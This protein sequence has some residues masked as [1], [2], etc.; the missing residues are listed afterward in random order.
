MQ[1]DAEGN[2]RPDRQQYSKGYPRAI[3]LK[4]F[5]F[6]GSASRTLEKQISRRVILVNATN[7]WGIFQCAGESKGVHAIFA[8]ADLIVS[9]Q[10]ALF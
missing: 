10:F 6:W 9:D 7:L 5:G 8:V 4:A 3:A 2:P 1:K